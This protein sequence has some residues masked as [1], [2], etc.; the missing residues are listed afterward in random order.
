MIPEGNAIALPFVIPEGDLLLLPLPHHA[1]ASTIAGGRATVS[2]VISSACGPPIQTPSLPPH[3][4]L[5]A[6]ACVR[7][8]PNS[9]HVIGD[10]AS[11]TPSETKVRMSPRAS[12]AAVSS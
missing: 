12:W 4:R 7:S 8:N 11:T 6:I 2:T 9:S 3:C 1:A 5:P 10:V